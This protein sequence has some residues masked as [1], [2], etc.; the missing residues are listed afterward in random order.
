DL[1][2]RTGDSRQ[3]GVVVQGA[4]GSGKTHMLG[5]ARAQIQRRGGYFFVIDLTSPHDFWYSVTPSNIHG[6]FLQG[7]AP[8]PQIRTIMRALASRVALPAPMRSALVGDTLVTLATVDQLI[9]AVRDYAPRLSTECYETTRALA[10]LAS[11]D[12][13]LQ[14]LAYAYLLSQTE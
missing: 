11:T 10:L 4:A 9:R 6:F 14:D 7:P 1:A 3:V 12:V 5:W 2:V 8:E 13:D